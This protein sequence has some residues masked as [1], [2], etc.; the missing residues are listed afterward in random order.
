LL[1]NNNTIL[2]SLIFYFFFAVLLSVNCYGEII[3]GT[4]LENKPKV[5]SIKITGLKKTNKRVILRELL[6]K[7][8]SPLTT[9]DLIESVQRL[10]NLQIFS[11]VR[12]YLALLPN[13][14]VAVTI[15][16]EEKWTTIPFFNY[17]AGGGT[18]HLTAGIYDINWLG[19]YI[20]LGALY[21]NW[22]KE[23]GGIIWFNDPRFLDQRNT[24]NL[25]IQNT[26]KPRYIYEENG[27]LQGSFI[28]HRKA[29][30][31]AYKKEIYSHFE[32]GLQAEYFD[33]ALLNVENDN[34]DSTTLDSLMHYTN[35]KTLLNTLTMRLGQLN[36]D[37]D[38]VSGKESQI[39]LS[40]SSKSLASDHNFNKFKWNNQIYWQFPWRS[41]IAG[42]FTLAATNTQL[43]QQQYFVGGFQHIRGYYD[44]QFRN[45]S[46][47]QANLEY[48]IPSYKSQWIVL[49]HVFFTDA[50]NA[51]SHPKK[52]SNFENNVYSAGTGIR[53]LS[54]KVYS[55]NGR[56]DFAFYTSGKNKTSISFGT[57]HFF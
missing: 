15:D 53:L 52:L 57:Q 14:E 9:N 42:N 36:Y 2:S 46:Y 12:P 24:L 28:L 33:D 21:Q 45:K 5:E 20:E 56:I 43:I 17:S 4:N 32:L 26:R 37:I 16:I 55:F 41:Y 7:E 6:F 13:N 48:R 25:I 18:K 22:N 8:N 27:N 47:W 39:L 10:K 51:A 1:N 38:I 49:Q 29:F 31:A 11:Y 35:S 44:G 34:L 30:T 3:E 54:P 19:K 23:H 50:I 40:H